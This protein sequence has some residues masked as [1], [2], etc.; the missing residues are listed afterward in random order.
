[1]T[2]KTAIEVRDRR[3]KNY[4]H[5][6]KCALGDDN[7]A[8]AQFCPKD[9]DKDCMRRRCLGYGASRHPAPSVSTEKLIKEWSKEKRDKAYSLIAKLMF[10]NIAW[11]KKEAEEW[12]KL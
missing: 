12:L 4:V 2:N 8:T 3:C 9:A 11:A 1:M 6:R 7:K 5:P 10:C